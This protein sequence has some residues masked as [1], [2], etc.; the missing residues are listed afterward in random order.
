LLFSKA[1]HAV[2]ESVLRETSEKIAERYRL[3][4]RKIVKGMFQKIMKEDAEHLKAS[5]QAKKQ[6]LAA[7]QHKRKA[8]K[9]SKA[10]EPKV[11]SAEKSTVTTDEWEAMLDSL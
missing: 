3:K 7:Q 8:G 2:S 9:S 6:R 4:A 11:P 5:T 10:V 1:E